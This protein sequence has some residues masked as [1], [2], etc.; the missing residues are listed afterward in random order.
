MNAVPLISEPSNGGGYPPSVESSASIKQLRVQARWA[1]L[2]LLLPWLVSVFIFVST[3][4]LDPAAGAALLP[5]VGV[6]LYLVQ[7]LWRNLE[8]NRSTQ[9]PASLY[10]T[11]GAANWL[12]L[13]RSA[14]VV[15][16]ACLLPLAHS[17]AGGVLYYTS[18]TA[19][20]VYLAVAL[21]DLVDGLIARTQGRVTELGKILDIETDAAGL[22]VAALVAVALDRI[23]G[24]Y[25][26]A[27]AIYYLYILALHLRRQRNLPLVHL[28]P[29][30]YGRITAGFQ[31]GLLVV[32]LIPI[33]SPLF[34]S[35]AAL[36]FMV[37]LVF[38]FGRDWLVVSGRL[39]TDASQQSRV[40]K[41][42]AQLTR[43]YVSPIIRI[44]MLAAC[45]YLL[46]TSWPAPVP[47]FWLVTV[48]G[49]CLLAGVGFLGR[50]ASLLLMLLL[51]SNLS[52]YEASLAPVL[53]F[54][55][56]VILLLCG[57]GSWSVWAPED[58]ILYRRRLSRFGLISG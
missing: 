58:D 57:T 8:K 18:L 9:D 32:V 44:I 35:I 22:L 53:I 52:P 6:A 13:A 7:T 11:L 51:G 4:R 24:F 15:S 48:G 12:T 31:M 5:A 26:A 16:L 3:S 47:F 43:V 42:A 19:S 33:F 56:A 14:A 46:M 36:F 25:L 2:L 55:G 49:T 10:N 54:A 30:P 50:G 27:G 40:D 34:C 28:P 41:L 23:P 17:Q 45:G 20:L 21:A 37:P 1:T 39:A 38:G 29:R